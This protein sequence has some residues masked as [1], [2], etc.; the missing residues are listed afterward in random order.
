M[1]VIEQSQIDDIVDKINACPDCSQLEAYAQKQLQ[2]WVK[3]MQDAIA[4]K[5]SAE[6]KKVAPTDLGSVI[7]WISQFVTE[8]Q[9]DYA[10]AVA[11]ISEV[12]SAYAQVS[13]AISSKIS[14]MQCSMPSIP[15]LPTP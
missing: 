8:A 3:T 4:S 10:K 9:A 14:S 2:V 7:S 11:T 12:T 1:S 15:T 5:A 6:A 13:A